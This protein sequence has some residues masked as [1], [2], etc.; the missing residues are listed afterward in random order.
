MHQLQKYSFG[1]ELLVQNCQ[2]INICNFIQCVVKINALL[3]LEN[4]NY[5]KVLSA[6]STHPSL[7]TLS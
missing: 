2:L 5:E 4:N 1:P 7:L 6:L 3:P